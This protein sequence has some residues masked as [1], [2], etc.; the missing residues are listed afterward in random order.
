MPTTLSV[1]RALTKTASPNPTFERPPATST[2]ISPSAPRFCGRLFF[3]SRM[4]ASFSR[5]R[6][7]P[8]LPPTV[9]PPL[10]HHHGAR[11]CILWISWLASVLPLGAPICRRTLGASCHA[12][13]LV[14]QLAPRLHVFQSLVV[15]RAFLF[16][17]GS[18]S[19]VLA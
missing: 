2:I 10:P 15:P 12:L 8:P 3:S 17:R 11:Y 16:R 4:S 9:F 19:L 13:H 7:V 14:G 18:F 1:G 5:A 6:W